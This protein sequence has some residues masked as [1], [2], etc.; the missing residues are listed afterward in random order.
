M[1]LMLL[2]AVFTTIVDSFFFFFDFRLILSFSGCLLAVK[3]LGLV[4]GVV[5]RFDSSGG[6]RVPHIGWNAV[7][8]CKESA[9]LDEIEGRHVY[10][11][12]SYRAL[13]V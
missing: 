12:H 9:I 10:F 1:P 5:G 2:L 7:N 3:G 6:I 11:V 8:I 4:P 13:P